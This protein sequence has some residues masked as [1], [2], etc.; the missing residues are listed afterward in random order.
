[1]QITYGD[2][3]RLIG[4][5]YRLRRDATV[6]LDLYWQALRPLSDDLFFPIYLTDR[7]GHELGATSQPQPVNYW[8]P[9]SRWKPGETVRIQTINLP[10]LAGGRSFGLAIGVTAGA[11][12]WDVGRRL[13]PAVISAPWRT[14]SLSQGTLVEAISFAN[15]RGL[16]S[17]STRPRGTASAPTYTLDSRVGSAIRLAGYDLPAEARAG[18]QVSVTLH[19]QAT[20]RRRG[21]IQSSCTCWTRRTGWSRSVTRCHRAGRHRRTPGW[22]GDAYEDRYV[23]DLPVDLPTGEYR[24]AV[25][26]Y[27]PETG[28]RLPTGGAVVDWG[29]GGAAD[30]GAGG[31]EVG[32]RGDSELRRPGASER[33]PA[34]PREGATT[35]VRGP[36]SWGLGGSGSPDRSS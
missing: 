12:P 29:C 5:D 6:D 35:S 34:C 19:W 21:S 8:Y 4:F 14:M 24:V 10:F 30:A 26:L 33:G 15:D 23:I 31:G 20:G 1:M 28:K 11:D 9:T 27:S 13:T 16:L 32:G 18:G 22:R 17:L 36:R 25:G 2:S 3:V 7:D